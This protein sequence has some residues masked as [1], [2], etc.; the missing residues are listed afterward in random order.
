VSD[1]DFTV[2]DLLIRDDG[3]GDIGG[4]ARLTNTASRPVTATFTFNVLAW[5]EGS[6]LKRE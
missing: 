3:F 2:R 4:I 1:K 6:P 5:R